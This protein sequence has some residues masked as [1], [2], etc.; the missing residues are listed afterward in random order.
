VKEKRAT[1]A[2]TPRQEAKRPPSRTCYTNVA[3]AGDWIRTGLPATLEGAVRSGREAAA[4]VSE[5]A[6]VLEAERSAVG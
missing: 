6:P 2:A 4:I 5:R 1:F 3:L